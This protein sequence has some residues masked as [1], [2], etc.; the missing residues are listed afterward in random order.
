MKM[1]LEGMCPGPEG[2]W[3]RQY[4]ENPAPPLPGHPELE[5]DDVNAARRMT[6]CPIRDKLRQ[7]FPEV[8]RRADQPHP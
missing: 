6:K 1:C 7:R 8:F 5:T 3:L 4:L 2:C